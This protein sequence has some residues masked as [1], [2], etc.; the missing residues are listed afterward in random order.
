MSKQTVAEAVAACERQGI[1]ITGLPKRRAKLPT[2]KMGT[3][4]DELHELRE[5]RLAVGKVADALKREE[6]RLTDHIIDTVD[7]DKE[8]GVMGT[9]YK[10]LILRDTV[11]VAE[12]WDKFYQH[13]KRTG[14]FHYLNKALNKGSLAERFQAGKPVPGIGTMG[15]KKLSLTKV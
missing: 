5:R 7:A 4:A 14:N 9:T 8:G 1:K 2:T 6:Q 13:V 11:Y 15:V 10:A 3:L 12:D